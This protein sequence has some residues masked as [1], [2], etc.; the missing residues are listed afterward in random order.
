M[1]QRKTTV[2]KSSRSAT[3]SSKPFQSFPPSPTSKKSRAPRQARM[4]DITPIFDELI[5]V[6]RT[7]HSGDVYQ[8][9]MWISDEKKYIRKTLKTR[10]KELAIATAKKEFFQYQARIQSGEKIFSISAKEM[11]DKYLQHVEQLVAGS[12]ISK[13]RATNIKTFTKHFMEFVGEKSKVQSIDRRKFIEYRPFR[14]KAKG[15]IR[16]SVVQNEAATI[17]QMYRWAIEEGFVTQKQMPDFGKIKVDQHESDVEAYTMQ[18]YLWLVQQSTNWHKKVGQL[19]P[20]RNEE[21]YYRQAINDFV[22]L[23]GHY[24]MRTGELCQIKFGDTTVFQDGTARIVIRKEVSKVKK[25]R[26]LRGI[27]GDVIAR[28]RERS[29]FK[30]NDNY[31]FSHY[32]KDA[33][34][35]RDK[36]YEY[37]RALCKIVKEKN[38]EFDDTKSLY[39]LRHL[40]ITTQLLAQTVSP[41]KI[42]KYAGT[43]LKQITATY[44]NID[45]E[46]IGKELL[47]VRV[48]FDVKNDE[49]I[50]LSKEM[51]EAMYE[52]RDNAKKVT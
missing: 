37:Y 34:I 6:Y 21:I 50:V 19:H 24:G 49:V 30:E 51:Y 31:L 4:S 3:T 14:Q 7:T 17:K 18:E 46:Q 1:S 40:W 32:T 33:E 15:D 23:M 47:K 27:K 22:L 36:L 41:Y 39:S 25:Q 45:D 13:G 20:N 10:D 52:E 28:R 48:K 42:A 2:G 16:M 38:P 11:R 26:V 29:P 44:D 43:S 35:P 9:R 12:Q 5:R 8:M